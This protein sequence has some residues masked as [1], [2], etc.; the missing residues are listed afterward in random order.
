VAVRSLE[1]LADQTRYEVTQRQLNDL[2]TAAVGDSS[3]AAAGGPRVIGGYIAD[4]GSLPGTVDDFLLCPVALANSTVQSFDSDRD[5]TDD[6]TLSSGW[7]GPY[8]HLGVGAADIIDGWG[9]VPAITAGGGGFD[10]TSL[11][12]DGDSIAPEDGYRAD[13]TVTVQLR[14]FAG[15]VL[16]RLFGIDSLNGSRIDPAPTGTEQLGVLFYGVNAAGG[17]SGQIEEQLL[18]VPNSGTFEY[19]R[20]NTFQGTVA[21]RAIQWDDVDSDDVL[22]VGETIVKKSYVHYPAVTP[23]MDVRVEME[24]R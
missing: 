19:R 14:D 17:S 5:A 24:L 8:I 10:L 9:R 6:V 23:A 1:P 3:Y 20:S 7:R 13:L 22:D 18:V 16:F 2:R 21:A 11:G 4:T 15:D 12:S